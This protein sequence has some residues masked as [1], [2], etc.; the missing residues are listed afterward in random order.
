MLD[1]PEAL[2]PPGKAKEDKKRLH[3]DALAPG[4]TK[5]AAAELKA[6][7]HHNAEAASLRSKFTLALFESPLIK[8]L[9]TRRVTTGDLRNP[10]YISA[11]TFARALIDTLLPD[12]IDTTQGTTASGSMLQRLGDAAQNLPDGS[13]KRSLQTLI[14]QSEG[15]LAKLE[16]SLEAW[17]DEQMAR[18]SGWYKRWSRVV[19][20]VVGFLVAILVNIDTLQVAHALYVDA[21]VRQA[22]VSAADTGALCQGEASSDARATCVRQELAELNAGGVPL[23]TPLAARSAIRPGA[24]PGPRAPT[25]TSGTFR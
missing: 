7:L 3:L 20:A 22:V 10:Q 21:P 5:A 19:L 11:T 24:G 1:G 18:I 13:L 16:R 6:V 14:T 4:A 17:Y 12:A 2:H 23:G 25:C 8:S 15:D 9:Q